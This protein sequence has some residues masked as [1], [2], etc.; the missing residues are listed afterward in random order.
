MAYIDTSVL[1]AYYCTEPLST[2]AQRAIREDEAPTISPLVEV[3]LCSAVALKVRRKELDVVAANRVLSLFQLH[4]DNGLYAM[5]PIQAREYTL[6]REWVG[7]FTTP[8]R[9][10]DALHLA[11]AFT[12]NLSL[13]TCDKNL[14]RCAREFGIEHQLISR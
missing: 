10:L 2:A 11:A 1:A 13:L 8:L 12:N 7:R 6:A 3:E 14:A 4:L 5:V 9:A